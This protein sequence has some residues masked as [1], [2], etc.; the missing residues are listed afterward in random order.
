MVKALAA[1]VGRPKFKFPASTQ[2]QGI[3]VP[4]CI[5]GIGERAPMEFGDS[6]PASG[7]ETA[8]S[9]FSERH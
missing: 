4:I 8:N 2:K 7:A 6:K 1:Q 5:P 9:G 3:A